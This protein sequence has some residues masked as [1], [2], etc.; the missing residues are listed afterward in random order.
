MKNGK[1]AVPKLVCGV[2]IND[3][4]Y[5]VEKRET[6][7]VNGKR[8]QKLIWVCPFYQTW[9]GMLKRCYSAKT[10]ERQPTYRGCSVSEEWHTFSNFKN[11]MEKQDFEGKQLDKDLLLE[12]NKVYGPETCVF[13]SGMVNN[14]TIDCGSAR[15]EWLIG[16]CWDKKASKFKSRCS[17]PFTNKQ[18]NLGYFKCEVEAHQTWLKRKLGLAHLLAAEQ[19]DGRV[20]KAL[21]ARYTNYTNTQ[22]EIYNDK[23]Y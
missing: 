9:K 7:I 13:V 4:D 15:G 16:V 5:V 6:I 1:S 2:G 21:I 3:A 14:F 20:A 8:K 11:W 22:K 23:R 17:N 18:E 12:G 19:T 10:Q